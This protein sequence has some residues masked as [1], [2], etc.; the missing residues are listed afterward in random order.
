M[1]PRIIEQGE[2][3]IVGMVYYGNPFWDAEAAPDQNEIGKLWT[4]FNTYWDSHRE[5]F[6]Q[7]VNAQVAWEL[8]IGTD[9]YEETK[10]YFVM[11]GVEVSKIEDLPAPTFAKV[12]PACQFA[13]FTLKGA[14][15][16]ANWGE[17]IYE[18][19]LPTSAYE[20][21]YSCTIERYDG[22]RF[23]GWGDPESEVEIWVPIKARE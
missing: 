8:H 2:M 14:Q 18:G 17:S 9:E 20:E 22:D 16:T 6:R 13:V 10:E 19:W 15:M 11:V 23:K 3:T 12:L 4:R 5:A 7:E 21:A 1:E